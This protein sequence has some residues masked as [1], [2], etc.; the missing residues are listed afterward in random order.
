M[1]DVVLDIPTYAFRLLNTSNS[2]DLHLGST[3]VVSEADV[4]RR[5]A[6]WNRPHS[7]S[8][9]GR[10]PASKSLSRQMLG[11]GLDITV[12]VRFEKKH[13]PYVRM[14]T[15]R[16]GITVAEWILGGVGYAVWLLERTVQFE[17]MVEG[18]ASK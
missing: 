1:V 5:A 11:L 4:T 13:W 10:V 6:L 16:L 7:F 18:G 17:G 2:F 12:R 14:L 8:G 3:N 9:G 15:D